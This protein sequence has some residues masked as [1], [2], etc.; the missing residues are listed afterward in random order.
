VL[1]CAGDSAC[2]GLLA[3]TGVNDDAG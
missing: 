1:F 2:D 3:C